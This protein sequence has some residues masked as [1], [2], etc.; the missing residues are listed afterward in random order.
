MNN[1]NIVFIFGAPDTDLALTPD[2]PR[3]IKL[4]CYIPIDGIVSK[5]QPR[6]IRYLM[7]EE[8]IL[9]CWGCHRLLTEFAYPHNFAGPDTNSYIQPIIILCC[10]HSC[11][12]FIKYYRTTTICSK[13]QH[14][15]IPGAYNL[16]LN[17]SACCPSCW[18]TEWSNELS[19]RLAQ[20]ISY[21]HNSLVTNNIIQFAVLNK[22]REL[23]NN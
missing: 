18:F 15:F 8:W 4:A 17:S 6:V 7:D 16:P 3:Q 23:N 20:V 11:K 19:D 1:N 21:K 12:S 13:C 9:R 14:E 10:S 2:I 22:C 5:C